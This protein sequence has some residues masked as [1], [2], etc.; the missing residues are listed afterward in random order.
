MTAALLAGACALL[1]TPAATAATF[2][3]LGE[4]SAGVGN[5]SLSSSYYEIYDYDGE[6]SG[7]WNESYLMTQ[8]NG[9]ARGNINFE[10]GVS[11]QLDVEGQNTAITSD[12]MSTSGIG[13]HLYTRDGDYLYGALFSIGQLGW[14]RV[15]T[16]GL[17]G[18]YIL[19]DTTIYA[20][21]TYSAFVEGN[22]AK[23]GQ[24]SFNLNLTVRHFVNENFMLS[25]NIGVGFG[26]YTDPDSPSD[27][28]DRGHQNEVSWEVRAEYL[29]D[30][31]PLSLFASYK[32]QYGI[33]NEHYG[34]PDPEDWQEWWK[35]T[36]R[37][38][39]FLVGL[40]FYFGQES[41]LSNDRTG[42][43]LEDR[44]PWYGMSNAMATWDVMD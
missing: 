39:M 34:Y 20:Q 26:S 13:A 1:I 32:G 19:P 42:A 22:W 17:E 38:H 28:F 8:I 15:V 6:Y 24:D 35:G 31:L 11:L 40:R 4:M 23:S 18:Q 14:G 9:L 29:L 21:A 27:Y 36:A 33:A 25:G 3:G 43:T 10:N 44:N 5:V 16:V 41:L 30:E 7:H 2:T 12:S 37:A